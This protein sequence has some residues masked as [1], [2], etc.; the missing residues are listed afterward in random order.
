MLGTL[1][2]SSDIEAVCGTVIIFGR[3]G[4]TSSLLEN[5]LNTVGSQCI[6][7][8]SVA[9]LLE[10]APFDD[11]IVV[12]DCSDLALGEVF[13]LLDRL[14][15]EKRVPL[16]AVA[17]VGKDQQ[18]EAYLKWANVRGIFH[19]NESPYYLL[20]G[21]YSILAGGSWFPRGMLEEFVE[22]YRG[23]HYKARPV[24]KE[25][26]SKARGLTRR[27]REILELVTTGA[28]NNDIARSLCLSPHTIKTHLYNLFRKLDVDNRLQAA[29][30]AKE[31]GFSEEGAQV[32]QALVG[33]SGQEY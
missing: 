32:G 21:V 22:R 14:E 1:K 23:L 8:Y 28:S 7:R 13:Q 5:A 26:A 2:Q 12:I 33:C 25:E 10:H 30:W 9:D 16:I 31:N 4:I 11:A 15:R 3:P 19:K 18:I 29:N 6:L 20:K 24:S 17:N 27:E